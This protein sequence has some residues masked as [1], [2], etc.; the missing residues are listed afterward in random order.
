VSAIKTPAADAP[1]SEWGALAVL[2]PDL[3]WMRGMRAMEDGHPAGVGAI[4]DEAWPDPDDPATAGCLLAMLGPCEV[5]YDDA[6]PAC[7]P[8]SVEIPGHFRMGVTI[9][10]AAIAVAAANGRWPGG[11]SDPAC[12]D[13]G[14]S[15]P[16]HQH[17]GH[18]GPEWRCP[19]GGEG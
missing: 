5:G 18:H 9:G 7:G 15:I 10:R 14:G 1:A 13:C 17:H 8:W 2:I 11:D 16:E 3:R 4:A 19:D 6:D 12:P